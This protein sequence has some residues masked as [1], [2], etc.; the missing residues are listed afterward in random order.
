MLIND[1]IE[2]IRNDLQ[3]LIKAN[4]DLTQVMIENNTGLLE[5]NKLM[6]KMIAAITHTNRI[7]THD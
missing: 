5:M 2:E 4:R 7:E 6:C 1:A 3:V